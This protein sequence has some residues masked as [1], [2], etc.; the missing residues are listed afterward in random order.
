MLAVVVLLPIV[1]M[2]GACL[3]ER[4]EAHA[5]H[6]RPEGRAHT[7]RPATPAPS[8]TPVP[9]LALVPGT[10]QPATDGPAAGAI[11]DPDTLRLPR[12]S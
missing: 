1:L 2:I 5:T 7:P 12:A 8:A 11:D 9:A 10:A 4:F 3:L 6:V